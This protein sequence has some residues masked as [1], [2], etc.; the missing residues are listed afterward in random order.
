MTKAAAPSNSTKD[1]PRRRFSALRRF[2]RD[3]HAA[4]AIEF[5]LVALPFFALLFAIL[6][7]FL[8]FFASQT[9]ETA[10]AKGARL[11]RTGQAQTMG[12][13][14]ATF[15]D[16]ICTAMN[17]LFNCED[18]L[19]VDVRTY[20]YFNGVD[21][22]QPIDEDGNLIEDFVYEPGVG[23]DVV[24]VRAFYEWPIHTNIL[25]LGLA[26]LANGKRLIAAATAFRN[27]PF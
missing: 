13:D 27:E 22:A 5:A 18:N 2:R 23:G 11:V 17:G 19:M 21:L 14:A 8:M 16:E 3:S 10:T 15:K 20:S 12:L 9:I 26:N 1:K 4:T 6:E 25:G 24:V 7:T